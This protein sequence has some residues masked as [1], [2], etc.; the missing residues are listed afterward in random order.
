[1][2]ILA[3]ARCGRSLCKIHT[4]GQQRSKYSVPLPLL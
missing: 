2:S 3:H 1:L 4:A